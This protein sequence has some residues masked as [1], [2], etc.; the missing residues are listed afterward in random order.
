MSARIMILKNPI[1]FMVLELE[2][3]RVLQK[4]K[5]TDG[6]WNIAIVYFALTFL[7]KAEAC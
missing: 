4:L 6:E 7:T 1:R 2:K 3:F 5:T